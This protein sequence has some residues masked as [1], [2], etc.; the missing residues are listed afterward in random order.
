M[1]E[2]G[3]HYSGGFHY[4]HI[5]LLSILRVETSACRTKE[6]SQQVPW[7]TFHSSHCRESHSIPR[8]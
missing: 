5:M 8:I 4:H 3:G 1:G 7:E 6:I 2:N